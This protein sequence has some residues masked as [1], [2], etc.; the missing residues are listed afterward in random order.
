MLLENNVSNILQTKDI[1]EII[2]LTITFLLGLLSMYFSAKTNKKLKESEFYKHSLKMK[3]LKI[4]TRYKNN[5][6]VIEEI[7][8]LL[9]NIKNLSIKSECYLFKNRKQKI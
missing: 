7:Y 3:E 1:I 8:E 4:D 6:L 5:Q 9:I 2:S